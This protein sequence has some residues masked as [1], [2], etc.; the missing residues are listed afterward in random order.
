[1]TKYRRKAANAKER[2]RMKNLN[3]V[4]VRLRN[5]IPDVNTLTHED[6]DTKVTTLRAAIS[7]IGSLQQLME[8]IDGGKVDPEDYKMG[9]ENLLLSVKDSKPHGI[10]PCRNKSVKKKIPLENQF[11]TGDIKRQVTPVTLSRKTLPECNKLKNKQ[12]L[13]SSEY[14]HA[15]TPVH[16]GDNSQHIGMMQVPGQG[17]ESHKHTGIWQSHGQERTT[18]EAKTIQH[19][20]GQQDTSRQYLLDKG[21]RN[22]QHSNCQRKENQQHRGMLNSL[23][24]SNSVQHSPDN[25]KGQRQPTYLFSPPDLLTLQPFPPFTLYPGEDAHQLD[26]DGD[27]PSLEPNNQKM[28]NRIGIMS[29]K[30]GDSID[31]DNPESSDSSDDTCEVFSDVDSESYEVATPTKLIPTICQLFKRS[32]SHELEDIASDCGGEQFFLLDQLVNNVSDDNFLVLDDIKSI[33]TQK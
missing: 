4:F 10:G 19:S 26:Q 3:K 13:R 16:R 11:W 32:F 2:E 25:V 31:G 15:S 28:E 9:E 29:D 33:I 1:M 5:I 7:Y 17:E 23:K 24:Q 18:D 20:L 30:N 12:T 6:K 21:E 8:D 27:K 14:I 22:Q